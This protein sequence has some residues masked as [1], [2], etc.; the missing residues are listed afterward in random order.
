M[1]TVRRYA[2]CPVGTGASE[3]PGKNFDN[4]ADCPFQYSHGTTK[5]FFEWLVERPDR[6]RHIMICIC[7][8]GACAT[9]MYEQE[10]DNLISIEINE[11]TRDYVRPIVGEMKL[12]SEPQNSREDDIETT[13]L[14]KCSTKLDW[15][16]KTTTGHD[17][18]G[19]DG[20]IMHVIIAC[21]LTEKK[22][23]AAS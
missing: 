14:G 8:D 12:V 5:V 9:Y 11:R 23:T 21:N 22:K 18:Y 4:A 16:S 20:S 13:S 15:L 10:V 7:L 1:G 3:P 6:S 2:R 17:H 19:R